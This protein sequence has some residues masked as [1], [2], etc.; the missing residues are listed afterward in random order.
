VNAQ[1]FV[2]GLPKEWSH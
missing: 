2:K 1:L